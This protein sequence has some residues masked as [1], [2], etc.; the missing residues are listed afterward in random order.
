MSQANLL[1]WRE[2]SK[3]EHPEDNLQRAVVQH[4]R[5]LAPNAIWY[6]PNNSPAVSK[7]TAAR[8]KALGVVAGIPDICVVL[9][10]GSAAFLELK[11]DK[12]RLSP[13]QLEFQTKCLARGIPH[14]VA[15]SLDEALEV[16]R[17]LG[18]LPTTPS[19]S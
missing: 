19:V 10:D 1:A 13:A 9:E 17:G 16:L 2:S 4:L 12:G 7:R 15:Y 3:R 8:Y 18:I 11:S 6:H 5:L 14:Y